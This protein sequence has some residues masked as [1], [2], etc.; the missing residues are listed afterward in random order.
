MELLCVALL[1]FSGFLE[2]TTQDYQLLGPVDNLIVEAG[3]DVVLTCYIR[4]SISA[5]NLT[6]E[7]FRLHLTN[8]LVHLYEAH[9]DRYE[10]QI[11]SYRGRTSLFKEELKKGNISLKLSA[12]R[13]SDDGVYKCFVESP[14]WYDDITIYLEVKAKV[15]HAWKIAVICVFVF[16]LILIA[17]TAYILQDKFSKKELTPAQC[18]VIAHMH[19]SSKHVRKEINLKKYKTSEEGYRRLIPAITNCTQARFTGCGLSEICI[20]TVGAALQ[21]EKSS[22]KELDFS[23]TNLQDSGLDLLSDGLKSSHCK[24]EKLQLVKSELDKQSGVILRSVLQTKNSLK[25]LDL[26][27]NNLQDAGLDLLS[28]G[29]KSPHC[30]LEILRLPICNLTKESCKFLA[31]S[32]QTEIS[33]LKE[34]DLSRNNVQDLGVELLSAGLKSLNCKLEILRLAWCN[35]GGSSCKYLGSVFMLTT[36]S[37]KELDLSNNDLQDSGVDLL[38][39]GLGNSNCKLII[40]RLSG[41]LITEVGCSSLASALNSN[42]SH[43]KE[44]DVTYNHPGDSGK[45]LLSERL[46]DPNYRLKTLRLEYAGECRIKPGIR[47]YTYDLTLDP[48]TAHNQLCLYEENKK[49]MWAREQ[50]VYLDNSHRFDVWNQV[51]CTE[52]LTGRCYWEAEWSEKAVIA[53]TYETISRKGTSYDCGFG[54]NEKSWR[55]SCSKNGYSVCHNKIGTELEVPPS[56]SSRVGV[57]LDWEGGT[58][59]FYSVSSNT[60]TLTHL[61]TFHCTFTE[62]VYAGFRLYPHSSISLLQTC[63]SPALEPASYELTT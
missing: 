16:S 58:L 41:C 49:V 52:S 7:W 26:S 35:L 30:K 11:D 31:S 38:S 59:S 6:V 51:L 9:E 37:L 19:H 22:L 15:F 10:Q 56:Y 27:N 3:E 34:L 20:E 13:T 46:N 54:G 40:L 47:K 42:P 55:L 44:L 29:L 43:L 53:V 24:L 14:S 2:T 8:T 45:N 60:H 4:P 50:Q 62:P 33:S 23:Y 18:A 63:S 5:E 48:N 21:S 17:F 32:L 36:S 61:H 57:Y 39:P 28:E 1:M 12:V 25:V